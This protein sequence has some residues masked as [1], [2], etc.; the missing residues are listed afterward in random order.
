MKALLIVKIDCLLNSKSLNNEGSD[1][2]D[3][4]IMFCVLPVLSPVVIKCELDIIY[5]THTTA[6]M[7]LNKACKLKVY[8]VLQVGNIIY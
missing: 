5:S 7:K 3:K 1:E 4:C 8:K 6:N 2:T